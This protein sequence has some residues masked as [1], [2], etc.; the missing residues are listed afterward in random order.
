M[1]AWPPDLGQN[2]MAVGVCGGVDHSPHNEWETE[3]EIRRPR[4]KMLLKTCPPASLQS[5]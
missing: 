5:F 3:R 2:I 4:D 1:V